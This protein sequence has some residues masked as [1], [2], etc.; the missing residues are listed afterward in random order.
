MEKNAKLVSGSVIESLVRNSVM[1]AGRK[2]VARF[3]T[4]GVL[5]NGVPNGLGHS[6]VGSSRD[7]D[8]LKHLHLAVSASNEA[9]VANAVR[10]FAVIQVMHGNS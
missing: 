10:C 9:L 7:V 3:V 5:A 4:A 6:D 1:F 2:E 8:V